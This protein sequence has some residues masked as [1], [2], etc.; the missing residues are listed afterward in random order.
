MIDFNL[1]SELCQS[2]NVAFVGF[3]PSLTVIQLQRD[4]SATSRKLYAARG[5]A[6]GDTTEE[7]I[8]GCMCEMINLLLSERVI[9]LSM[10]ISF[11]GS[12]LGD[13]NEPTS[14]SWFQRGGRFTVTTG[15]DVSQHQCQVS[16]SNSKGRPTS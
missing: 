9:T 16:R 2:T 15:R 5:N 11:K 14:E 1:L 3:V 10:R 7:L 8:D 12:I 13:E 4:Q 6:N